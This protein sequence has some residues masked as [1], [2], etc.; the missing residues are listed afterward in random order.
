VG[1]IDVHC[2]LYMFF[3]IKN[4]TKCRDCWEGGVRVR[5]NQNLQCLDGGGDWLRGFRWLIAG[6]VST[7]GH[8]GHHGG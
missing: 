2:V 5:S 3:H 4:S 1:V 7:H 6:A 8:N